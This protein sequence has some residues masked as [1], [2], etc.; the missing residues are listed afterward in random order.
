MNG[1]RG[2]RRGD[3]G[4]VFFS[5]SPGNNLPLKMFGNMSAHN[6]DG[7]K[8]VLY[9]RISPTLGPILPHQVQALPAYPVHPKFPL[10]DHVSQ[11][12]LHV[13]QHIS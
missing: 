10:Q 4:G 8:T 11:A 1:P 6:S 13:N 12:L 9:K 2:L 5:Q 7:C 3:S